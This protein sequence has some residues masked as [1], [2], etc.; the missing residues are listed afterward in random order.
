MQDSNNRGNCEWIFLENSLFFYKA[1]YSKELIVGV[2][3]KSEKLI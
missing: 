3:E 2:G 1:N